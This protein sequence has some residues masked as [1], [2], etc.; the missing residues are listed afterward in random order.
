[1]LKSLP[2]GNYSV[3]FRILDKQAFS[4]DQSLYVRVCPCLEGSTC[5]PEAA[6]ASAV[7]GGGA[8]AAILA[9]IF[10]LMCE[11]CF[12]LLAKMIT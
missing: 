2:V 1:M 8:I 12:R 5:D 11:W 3:P 7:V 6:F 9:A 4:R 10:L